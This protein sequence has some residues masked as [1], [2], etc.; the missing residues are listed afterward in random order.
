MTDVPPLPD[1]NDPFEVLG[2]DDKIDALALRRAYVR[3]I[4]IY[5]PD[6]HPEEFARVR[7]AYEAAQ[8]MLEWRAYDDEDED[9]D[10]YDEADEDEEGSYADAAGME[11]ALPD[12]HDDTGA[13]NG[14]AAHDWR[15]VS[16]SASDEASRAGGGDAI[17]ARIAKAWEA[18][19]AGE[20]P[21]VLLLELQEPWDDERLALHRVLLADAG[22][23]GF[24]EHVL[25][26]LERGTPLAD[27][28]AVVLTEV[29]YYDLL[30][31]D[32]FTWAS[33]RQQTERNGAAQLLRGRLHTLMAHGRLDVAVEQVLEERFIADAELNPFLGWGAQEVLAVAAW[34]GLDAVDRLDRLYGLPTAEDCAFLSPADHRAAASALREPWLAW[35]REF[36]SFR[37]LRRFIVLAP[38]FYGGLLERVADR[39]AADYLERSGKYAACFT[40][41]G[42]EAPELIERFILAAQSVS[43]AEEK[44]EAVLDD[45][46]I[47]K[48]DKQALNRSWYRPLQGVFDELIRP[49]LTRLIVQ[50]DLSIETLLGDLEITPD[51]LPGLRKYADWIRE[52]RMFAALTACRR[53]ARA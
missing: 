37:D 27:W 31:D 13:T 33:L 9:E 39:L 51:A 35:R 16:D 44:Q 34:A 12:A 17:R 4:R 43:G 36:Q 6:R 50:R 10:A 24:R 8:R 1:S 32:A 15:P 42:E 18:L 40:R 52:E 5:R 14:E 3:L 19:A 7:S 26:G 45:P 23:L 49:T 38:V 2:V 11:D 30:A 48:L 46:V 47:R 20:S 41:L 28:L 29:E 53:L 21:E 22:G 25:A